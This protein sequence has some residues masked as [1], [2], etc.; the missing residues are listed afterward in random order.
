MDEKFING[1]HI[2]TEKLKKLAFQK[3]E[4]Q[5]WENELSK[6]GSSFFIDMSNLKYE[7]GTDKIIG[8]TKLIGYSK[9][10]VEDVYYV[11]LIKNFDSLI[12]IEKT[13]STKSIFE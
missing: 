2:Y 4:T 9:E 11:P 8:P 12:F 13:N 3:T 1:D 5:L 10:S 7:L 6:N